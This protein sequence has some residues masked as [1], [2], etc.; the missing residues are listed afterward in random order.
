MKNL[1][2]Y[3]VRGLFKSGIKDNGS[4]IGKILDV[5]NV[6]FGDV[7]FIGPTYTNLM[8]II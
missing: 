8:L 3:E 5:W 1:L 7:F 2:R 4:N 6:A